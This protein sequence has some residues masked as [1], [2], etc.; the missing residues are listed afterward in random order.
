MNRIVSLL[1]FL[2][3]LKLTQSATETDGMF[4]SSADLERLLSTEAEL[5]RAL[6]DYVHLEEDRLQKL[7]N[8]MQNYDKVSKEATN[9]VERYIGN[10]LNS[11]LLIKRL[12]SDWKELKHLIKDE[13]IFTNLTD[14]FQR[15]LKWPSEEDLSGAA[16][17]LTRLQETYNLDPTDLTHGKLQG[18]NYGTTLSAHD[19][20]ELGRQHYNSGDYDHSIVWMKEA[21]KR[22]DEEDFKTAS[23]ADIIEYIAFSYYTL[24]NLKKALQYT[25]ELIAIQP[26]HPRAP[27]NKFYYETK[28]AESGESLE[29]KLHKKGEDGGIN[30]EPEFTVTERNLI[31]N[32]QSEYSTYKK[33]CRGEKTKPNQHEKDLVC[34]YFHGHHPFLKIAPYKEEELFLSPRIVLYYDVLTE[35]E[36]DTVKSFAIPRFRRATVQNYKT[37]EL[38]TANYRI[39]KTAWIKR[40]EDKDIESIYRRVGDVT[41]LNMETSEELQVSNYGIGGHYEPHFDFA[42][43]EEANA[44]TSLGTGNRIAT[45][46]F[47]VT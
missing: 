27:G 44:F 30:A 1:V 11:F 2:V 3:I 37:G 45:W 4:T 36:F 38:E 13:D 39:S 20:F 40:E 15:P 43:R 18:V 23:R 21:L 17:A 9:D 33:L 31:E 35:S 47:Y 7:K 6:K 25:N 29:D 16:Q 10:P 28:L 8:V 5:V 14:S 34:R 41:G 19:C 24:D 42:R 32:A 12:T 22:L 26:D 46:L